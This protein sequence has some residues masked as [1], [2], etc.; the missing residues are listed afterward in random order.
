MLGQV[1][2]GAEKDFF[3]ITKEAH[4]RDVAKNVQHLPPSATYGSLVTIP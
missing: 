1:C 4:I 2:D 3:A